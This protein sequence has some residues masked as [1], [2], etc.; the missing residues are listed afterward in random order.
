MGKTIRK[1]FRFRLEPS[2]RQRRKLVRFVGCVRWTWNQA[3][4]LQ[5][6][7]LDDGKSVMSYPAMSR[8]VTEWRH[9]QETSWLS[10]APSDSCQQALRHLRRAF[11]DFFDSPALPAEVEARSTQR[12][13][14][15]DVRTE[16][17]R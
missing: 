11:D 13:T 9:Q 7:R 3:L 16:A 2:Y 8:L 14:A 6:K 12:S 15:P 4:E 10:E 5:K 17:G 1:A